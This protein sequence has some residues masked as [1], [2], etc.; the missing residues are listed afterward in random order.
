M[1]DQTMGHGADEIAALLA[2]RQQIQG[3]LDRLGRS[4]GSAPEGVRRR[5]RA[6]YEARLTE[7]V[8]RLG[9]F[10]AALSEQLEGV[11][12]RQAELESQ[13]GLVEE[14]LAEAELR[15]AVGEFTD[16]QWEELARE[17]GGRIDS[18]SAEIGRLAEEAGRLADVL[19]QV[20]PPGLEAAGLEEE[21]ADEAEPVAEAGSVAGAL[22]IEVMEIMEVE[23]AARTAPAA[24]EAPRFTPKPG[25]EPR[26]RERSAPRTLRFPAPPAPSEP[27][28]PSPVDEMTFL[29]SVT[30]ESG[31]P[32]RERGIEGRGIRPSRGGSTAAKTPKCTECG[33]M[34]RPTE[35]YCE[36]CGA[37]LAAV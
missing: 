4:S 7:V 3:W 14:A 37:E 29:K 15:H 34:N 36:R 20:A 26:P 11:R 33:A 17:H 35:W 6:D 19:A 23:D 13:R 8:T 25:M 27:A 9:S 1:S 12:S 22:E 10:S 31:T 2:D 18:L 21:M 28:A 30:L 16:S 24:V 32:P 5:V